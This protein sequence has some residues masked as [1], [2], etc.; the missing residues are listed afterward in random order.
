MAGCDG[1]LDESGLFD[2]K[3]KTMN[4]VRITYKLILFVL[5][6][7]SY[8]LVS[9][10][11]RVWSR[12]ILVRRHHYTHTVSFFCRLA[13]WLL[14]FRVHAK[15]VP[16]DEKAYLLVGNHLGMLD[17]LVAAAHK[18]SLFV[19][20]V[21]MRN[22]PGLGFLAEMGGC[23]YVERR[24][25]SNITN[26]IGEIREVLRQGFSVSLYPEGTSTNGERVLPFKKTLMTSAAGTGVP[27][28]PM[29]V[30]YR[31][32]NGEPMSHKWRDY[33]CWYGDQTFWP[34]LLRIFTVKSVDVDFE[35][36]PEVMVH[37]EEERRVIAAKI[38]SMVVSKYD[39]IPLPPGETSPYA[40][41]PLAH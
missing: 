1:S 17:I 38:Q 39:P 10:F 30:N 19:T 15:N 26:E 14:R 2:L 29:V 40:H 36:L 9:L 24:S 41:I 28:L 16:P 20:S 12:D 7:L 11:W 27:I 3:L 4:L 21:E 8:V 37:S 33:V 31:K 6:I 32:I 34:A 23:L 5:F 22:T 35:Y 13:L 18:P 25:R